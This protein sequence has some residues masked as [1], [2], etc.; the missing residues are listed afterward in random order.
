MHGVP[1]DLG[2]DALHGA[3]LTQ[4]AIGLFQVQFH[5]HPAAWLAVEGEWRLLDEDGGQIERWTV[6]SD[7]GTRPTVVHQRVGHRI[8]SSSIFVPDSFALQFDD[9]IVLRVFDSSGEFESF[10]F[11]GRYV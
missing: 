4:V 7:W 10:S 1:H 9:G 2:L 5:F 11:N 8:V 3:E 6:D